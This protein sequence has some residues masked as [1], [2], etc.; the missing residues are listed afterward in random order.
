MKLSAKLLFCFLLSCAGLLDAASSTNQSL[1]IN[2]NSGRLANFTNF[3]AANTNLSVPVDSLFFAPLLHTH[4]AADITSGTIDPAR[5]GSGASITTKYLR[6]DSTWQTITTGSGDALVANPLSQ[7][8]A[9]TS[10]QLRGVISDE[11]GSGAAVFADNPTLT[12]ASIA[13]GT[14]AT[15]QPAL[16]IS[17]TWNAGGVT[18]NGVKLNVTDTASAAGS[19]LAD[20][21]VGG[22]SV[23]S[24]TKESRIN[25][26]YAVFSGFM[27]SPTIRVSSDSGE[28]TF[29][30][31]NDIYLRRDAANT[32]AQR[33][34]VNAQTFRLY[35]TYTD[36]SNYERMNLSYSSGAGAFQIYAD[37][38][39]T[40]SARQMHIGT[41]GAASLSLVTANVA[42]WSIN[43]SGSFLAGLDNT[44]DIGASGA[45][46][47]R[48]GYFGTSIVTPA[49][50]VSNVTLTGT[51]SFPAGTRQTFAPNTTT[52]GINV[53]SVASDPSTPSNGDLWLNTTTGR[54][55]ARLGGASVDLASGAQQ[56]FE[57]TTVTSGAT[58]AIDLNANQYQTLA[59]ATDATTVTTSN[60]S[61]TKGRAVT[62][63]V[64][65]S[66]A[67]RTFTL[68][69]S[70]RN[71][72]GGSTSVVI[73]SGK[74][75]A[76]SLFCTG[77][78]ETDVRVSYTI[79]P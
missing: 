24:V 14:I 18:F 46:R 26:L 30:T 16:D 73:P 33:N 55:K 8:A 52:P 9:T 11:T 4:A 1:V 41:L 61:A 68:N 17:Q 43:S 53:G 12:K 19:L 13:T 5:L 40:G 77:S 51:I 62:L 2:T 7:F 25:S 20:F 70:W 47:P 75:A 69:G 36:A 29:G 44:Y 15:S 54:L 37:A 22:S 34:G 27:Y 74:E 35:N 71:F 6:G 32:L 67:Q 66:G 3:F 49:A 59:L 58:I 42:K 45:T 56:D 21:Q 78:A 76:I 10:A 48:T 72:N 63:F 31:S 79:Q 50:T 38:A 60:R 39:G 64:L 65:A 28:L 57:L 23:F